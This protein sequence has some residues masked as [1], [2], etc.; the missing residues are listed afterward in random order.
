MCSKSACSS[1]VSSSLPHAARKGHRSLVKFASRPA[2]GAARGRC[3]G[4]F[5]PPHTAF[6]VSFPQAIAATIG[7]FQEER[8][9][10]VIWLLAAASGVIPGE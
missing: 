3:Q 5:S 4:G 10:Y 9:T 6:G 1:K 7:A 8:R 2:G